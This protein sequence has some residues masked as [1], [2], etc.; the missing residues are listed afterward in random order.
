MTNAWNDWNIEDE[1]KDILNAA[2]SV[3]IAESREELFKLA[4][5]GG[6]DSFDVEYELLDGSKIVEA[7]VV[8][9]KNGLA[10]N[11]P[12]KNMRR[13][14]P[15][16]MV[17]G[18]N[19]VTDKAKYK[20]VFNKDFAPIRTETFDWLK[21]QELLIAGIYIG[22]EQ[23]GLT[24]MIIAPANAGFFVG[25]LADLQ[26]FIDL[27][28]IDNSFNPDSILYLAPPFRHT[29]YNGKQIV[30]HNRKKKVHE[31][32]SYNLYPGPSAKKGI[33]GVLLQK[34][35]EEDWLTL[36]ASTVQVVTP[37]ENITTFLHEGASG[38]GKSEMLEH[39]HR[40]DDGRLLL[41]KNKISD[42]TFYVTINQTC[43]LKPVT[44]DMALVDNKKSIKEKKLVVTDAE[45]AWFLRVNHIGHYG[46]DPYLEK[47]TIHPAEPLL[48]INI[49][50]APNST[51][52]LWE[53]IQDAPGK[54]CPN[55]RVILPRKLMPSIVNT[56]AEV[57]FRSFG[58]R[59]PLCSEKNPSYG[60]VGMFHILPPALA[61]LW[62]LVSPRGY[63]NPS[64]LD[65]EGLS[66]EGVGSYWPFATGK[67]VNHANLLLKQIM[68]TPNT[69]YLL[70]PNQHIGSWEVRFMPQWIS[71][72][73]FARRGAARFTKEQLKP[74]RCPLL[75]YTPTRVVV[76]GVQIPE[77][78]FNVEHQHEVGVEAYDYGK[79]QLYKF[80]E[81]TLK[82]YLVP[83]LDP[84]G[85]KIIECCLER[86]SVA[87][88]AGLISFN[89]RD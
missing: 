87:E 42:K 78:F 61:W 74:A 16:C 29:H 55:P 13:R 82:E 2:P 35:E 7:Q 4:T 52:L 40:E 9:C 38:S 46:T 62:R 15:D 43:G 67:Y 80:F 66:S 83:E 8:K 14:D 39:P 51:I 65:E 56:P 11:Y 50:G 76:E 10:I 68:N 25:G 36:H 86:G 47:I 41:G 5:N 31:I 81:K 71:R 24:G 77:Y 33:Y 88:M 64:I 60:I 17:V 21:K 57:D 69:K 26:G 79:E 32:F 6:Q 49:Q 75:G 84:L 58:I 23:T 73:Y 85:K 54:A 59:T 70:F 1:I 27:N 28:K 63:A 20:D 3:T 89:K 22:G 45:N 19:K 37:Y 18:D 44:D 48:F 72:E 53:H 12:D 34:G 30:V